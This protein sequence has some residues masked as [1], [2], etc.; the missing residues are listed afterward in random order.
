MALM[1]WGVTGIGGGGGRSV[2]LEPDDVKTG[3]MKIRE[4]IWSGRV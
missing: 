3:M 4:I 2:F 1:E